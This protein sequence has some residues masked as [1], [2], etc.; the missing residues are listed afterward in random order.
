M[1]EDIKRTTKNTVML[2]LMNIAKMVFPLITL[3][4][5][6]R[7]LSVPGYGMVVYVKAIMQYMQLFVDFGFLLSGTKDI[8]LAHNN[9]DR[10]NK[11][12]S[13]IFMAKLLLSLVAFLCLCCIIPFIQLLR[14][15]ILF[16]FLSYVVVFLTC[17]L[18]DFFFR[19][20]EKM[21]IITI[22]FVVMRG[23]ATI[24]TFFMV[25]DDS[26]LLW[27]PVL[28]I[29]GSLIAIVLVWH[30]IRKFGIKIKPEGLSQ[31][32]YKIKDSAVYFFSDMATT[33]FNALNTVLIGVYIDAIGVAFWGVCMQMIGAAQSLYTPITNGIYPQMV[34][35]KDYSLLK[36]TMSIFMPVVLM[37]C[38]FT[39]FVAKYAVV[40]IAGS[41]YE[42]AYTTLRLLIPVL[43]FSFPSMLY[44]WPALGAINKQNETTATTVLCALFQVIALGILIVTK[45]FNLVTIS[46]A[47]G[48]T[49]FL[50]FSS[51]FLLCKKF[52]KL[53]K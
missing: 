28:D 51:R 4:Y 21:E 34:R 38:I 19:G 45:R 35:T 2:Y 48:C 22:R 6:T 43:L 36:K 52:K 29:I 8:V 40:I 33:A 37:G 27:I 30:E 44:G 1:K 24:L 23:I 17:F 3:P 15:N 53:F 16:V 12:T 49:E 13:N 14:E 9:H 47:R 5:L 7:V 46:I 41:K 42:D 26:D 11:E 10:L 32:L 39:F 18:M 20:I 50:L 25:K 31:V